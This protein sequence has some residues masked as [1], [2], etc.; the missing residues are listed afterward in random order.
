MR[1]IRSKI[2]SMINFNI[3]SIFCNVTI[4]CFIRSP[5]PKGKCSNKKANTLEFDSPRAQILLECNAPNPH[6]CNCFNIFAVKDVWKSFGEPGFKPKDDGTTAYWPVKWKVNH[7]DPKTKE[8][9]PNPTLPPE[10][11]HITEAPG[12]KLARTS[13]IGPWMPADSVKV[14]PKFSKCVSNFSFI[15]SK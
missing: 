9:T 5:C 6:Q 7:T 13:I 14:E 3:L 15:D 8:E 10:A 4:F 11:F 1:Q 2:I 12:A